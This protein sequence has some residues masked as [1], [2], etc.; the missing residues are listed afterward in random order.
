MSLTW[1]ISYH[2]YP[3]AGWTHS[4]IALK[5]GGVLSWG[6]NSHY[7]LGRYP[8]TATSPRI[9]AFIPALNAKVVISL[10]CGRRHTVALVRDTTNVVMSWGESRKGAL[11]QS[12][13]SSSTNW[14][15]PGLVAL[16]YEK[17]VFIEVYSGWECS[18]ALSDAG[19]VLM[20]GDNKAG[21]ICKP[22]V[23]AGEARGRVGNQVVPIPTVIMVIP[24]IQKLAV[25]WKH[26][27]ALSKGGVVFSWGKNNYGQRGLGY[28]ES[29]T[30]STPL[31]P[32]EILYTADGS[33]IGTVIDIACGSEH[34]ALLNDASDLY[35][36]GWNEHGNLGLGNKIPFLSSPHKVSSI[37]KHVEAVYLGGAA[38]I[39]RTK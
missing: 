4:V 38:T 1:S 16:D 25:G 24:P 35:T 3:I 29:S 30:T 10:G 37:T 6:A 19:D 22:P 21:Q 5:S 2:K 8:D 33:C 13:I 32:T 39:I 26:V 11:G 31:Q 34:C 14:N 27:L 36:W 12:D 15:E 28:E 17:Y 7:Q 20:W 18:A 23:V 9:P